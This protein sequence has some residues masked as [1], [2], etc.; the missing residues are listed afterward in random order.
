MYVCTCASSSVIR[1]LAAVNSWLSSEAV[2]RVFAGRSSSG[3]QVGA[4]CVVVG[5]P[6][7]TSTQNNTPQDMHVRVKITGKL[8]ARGVTQQRI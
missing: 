1:Q 5:S 6:S 8:E 7:T 3:V 4:L 2:C